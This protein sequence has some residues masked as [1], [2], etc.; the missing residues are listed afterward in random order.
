MTARPPLH[1]H[2]YA[3]CGPGAAALPASRLVP[4]AVPNAR[5]ARLPGVA[6]AMARRLL[7][8]PPADERLHLLVGTS[9][10]CATETEQFLLHMIEAD[11]AT[12]KPRAFSQSVHCAIAA[13]VAIEFG[14]RGEAQTI[15]HGEVSF[16]LATLA[17][18]A[19]R[20]RDPDA[21]ILLGALDEGD[22]MITRGACPSLPP[23]AT[24]AG[25]LL[26]AAGPAGA[27]AELQFVLGGRAFDD[28]AARAL[29]AATEGAP[30][31]WLP[32][33]GERT[34]PAAAARAHVLPATLGGTATAVALA[35][36]TVTGEL[37]PTWL[38]LAARPAALAVATASRHRD[39]NAVLVRGRA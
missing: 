6:T 21:P 39:W 26:L 37:P 25:A 28:T 34:A 23:H 36:A 24:E 29:A 17:A 16:G 9:L 5:K 19:L 4:P 32:P 35:L 3:A 2:G 8:E 15:T 38:G 1:V 20:R 33:L 31:L 27:I 30:L 10:G 12:P 11:E 22:T 13:Q 14:A 18:H 7:G